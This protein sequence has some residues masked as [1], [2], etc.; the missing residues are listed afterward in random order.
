MDQIKIDSFLDYQFISNPKWS[1]EGEWISYWVRNPDVQRD[2]Y[3]RELRLLDR[4]ETCVPVRHDIPVTDCLWAP[5]E[6]RLILCLAPEHGKT[7]LVSLNPRTQELSPYAQ[8]P[9]SPVKLEFFSQDELILTVNRNLWPY[10][11]PRYNYMAFRE[12]PFR[13]NGGEVVEGRR[14]NLY[15]YQVKTGRCVP[16]MPGDNHCVVLCSVGTQGVVFAA[17]PADGVPCDQPGVYYWDAQSETCQTLLQPNTWYVR[18]LGWLNGRPV[19]SGSKGETYGRYQYDGFYWLDEA[20]PK[21]LCRLDY[22]V[23]LNS[24]LTD[25]AM[26]A[27]QMLCSRPDGIYFVSTINDRSGVYRLNLDGTVA[28]PLTQCDVVTGFDECHG[29]IVYCGLKGLELAELYLAGTERRLTDCSRLSKRYRLHVPKALIL[30]P[31]GRE[32]IHGW[33]IEPDRAAEGGRLP[34][35]F[36]IH[37]GPRSSYSSVFS[38]EMQVWV[39]SGYYVLFCNPRGSDSRGNAFGEIRGQ[40]GSIDYQDLMDFVDAALERYPQIDPER[41]GVVGGSY[42]GYMVNWIIGHTDRF[43]AAVSLRSISNWITHECLSDI[44]HYY[45]EDQ[46]GGSI[47]SGDA[48]KMWNNSPLKYADRAIT[49]TLFIH[50]EQDF[51]CGTQESLQM[52]YVL[53][54]REIPC[55]MVLFQGENHM[56]GVSG[57]PRSRIGCMKETLT[58]LDQHLKPQHGLDHESGSD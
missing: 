8:L 18:A 24:V 16:L 17:I 30:H 22:C 28:G 21:L 15:V 20:E 50:A 35:I 13:L 2:T 19:F 52:F 46:A 36:T 51:R 55:R 38:H 45:V 37:G 26:G 10:Q 33:V 32:E 57:R 47:L 7:E 25:G 3:D 43:R 12:T 58:W 40:Y 11:F 29:E 56:L 34:A 6:E 44:G 42:G 27:G 48:E 39:A 1:S 53:R 41:V 5:E 54:R 9:Y 49:P 14:T 4:R 31:Q 23:G